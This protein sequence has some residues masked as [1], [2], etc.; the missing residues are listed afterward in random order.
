MKKTLDARTQMPNPPLEN[1]MFLLRWFQ[2]ERALRKADGF[3]RR[4]NFQAALGAIEPAYQ[5]DPRD[6]H[7]HIQRAWVLS[8]LRRYDDAMK[9]VDA[10]LALS[11]N[12][13]I[14]HLVKGEILYALKSYEAA[15]QALH[16]ALELAGENLRIEYMLG[17]TYVA[18]QDMDRAAQFFE[19][20]VRYDK[21]L[22]QSRLLAM[23]ERYLFEHRT[24]R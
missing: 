21:S 20:S 19:S 10:G 3:A 17:M 14:L 16:R 24:I 11:S 22:V 1:D 12:N 4:G 9:T 18:L 2:R 8:E 7:L 23:A 5:N 13:G 6:I 15:C